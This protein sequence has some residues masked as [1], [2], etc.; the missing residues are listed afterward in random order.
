MSWLVWVAIVFGGLVAA[1]VIFVCG[2]ITISWI[3]E[4]RRRVR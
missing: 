2:L 4:R 1:D 3:Q